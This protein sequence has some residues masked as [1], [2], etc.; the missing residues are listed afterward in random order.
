MEYTEGPWEVEARK[1]GHFWKAEVRTPNTM[2]AEGQHTIAFGQLI[3]VCYGKHTVA[4]AHLIAASPALY[5]ACKEL[6][7][8]YRAR[9]FDR[10]LPQFRNI[11]KALV[12][13]EAR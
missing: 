7:E 11:Q 1:A 3:A 2:D 12:K 13:A 10:E 9:G 4:N 5:E 8:W 6:E